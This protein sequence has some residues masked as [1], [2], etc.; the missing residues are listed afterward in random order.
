M[1]RGYPLDLE[2]ILMQA[3]A[4]KREDRFQTAREFSRALQSLLTRR[5]L[6]IASDEVAAYMASIFV[7]RIAKREEHLRWASAVSDAWASITARR[8]VTV[9]VSV[10]TPGD[11]SNET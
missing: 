1:V 7:D 6:F 8:L 2:K 4:K 11:S 9:V 3:L 10:K 5:G